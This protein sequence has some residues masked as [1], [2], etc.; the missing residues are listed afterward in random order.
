MKLR[1][2]AAA[3]FLASALVAC[4]G[5]S[6]QEVSSFVRGVSYVGMSVSDLE[7][8]SKVYGAAAKLQPVD[9]VSVGKLP[10]LSAVQ[11]RE[12]IAKSQSLRSSNVQMRVMEFQRAAGD[13]P[14]PAVP[15]QGP[16]IAHVCYQVK[17]QTETYQRFLEQGVRPIGD[18]EM[19]QLSPIK[20]VEYVYVHDHDDL[21][22]E[23]EHVDV[24][25]LQWF[26]DIPHDYRIRHVSLGTPD[27]D[28]AVA[29]YSALTG[30]MEPRRASGL[31]SEKID[32]V[33]G[34]P[35]SELAMSWFQLGNL[36]LEIIQ[37]QSHPTELPEAPR[38]IDAI[39]YNLIVLDVVDIEEA[40]SRS[41]SGGGSVVA[42]P[43]DFEGEKAMFLRDP[44][45]NLLVVV[46][47]AEDSP[48]SP[49]Q[50]DVMAP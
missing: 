16:G 38:P 49:K 11:G 39:G 26:M 27:M 40:A 47:V 33:S 2:F 1:Q 44:D 29:Y 25:F 21:M 50:F 6:E 32:R 36:E 20:P 8:T 3:A 48:L 10:A 14:V 24:T 5:G 42:G 22:L 7:R 43:L 4:G 30:V 31:K 15:V 34:L 37:Y 35:G 12:L 17:E 45:G 28:R 9:E 19:V 13:V 41:I 23:I 46:S 18:P